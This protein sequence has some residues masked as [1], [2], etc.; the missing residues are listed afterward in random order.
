MYGLGQEYLRLKDNEFK[1]WKNGKY[2]FVPTGFF[3]VQNFFRPVPLGAAIVFAQTLYFVGIY[4]VIANG[5]W[6]SWIISELPC[7][8]VSN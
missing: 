2:V 7:P 1:Y 6:L 4:S 5:L 8:I 3:D